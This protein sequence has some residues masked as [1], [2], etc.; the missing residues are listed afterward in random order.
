MIW[1]SLSLVE[2]LRRKPDCCG[3]MMLLVSAHAVSLLV[4]IFSRILLRLLMSEMGL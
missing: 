2:W 3:L 4:M 1:N